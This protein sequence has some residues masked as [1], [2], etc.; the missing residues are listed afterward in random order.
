[1]QSIWTGQRGV[2]SDSLT[3]EVGQVATGKRND[4][5]YNSKRHPDDLPYPKPGSRLRKKREMA[6]KVL[7][8][9]LHAQ[10]A[11]GVLYW[12]VTKENVGVDLIQDPL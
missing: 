9:N 1:M 3:T 5:N 7:Q 10:S 2:K 4:P 12:R 8:M 11:K 6:T